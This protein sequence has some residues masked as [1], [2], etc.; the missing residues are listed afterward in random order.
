MRLPVQYK[1]RGR[2]TKYL[3]KRAL[4]RY[5]PTDLVYQPKRGFGVP[6]A[7][8]LRGPLRGWC[9]DL[10]HDTSI[11]SRL[12]LERAS[13]RELVKL[14]LAGK[15]ETH[16]VLWATLML[17]CFVAR[18]DRRMELPGLPAHRAAA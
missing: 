2:G 1:I 13:I 16:P 12:P 9:E 17:L 3:L 7:E 18:H 4:S 14:H 6:I 11:M 15:R 8:W 5:L 10:I